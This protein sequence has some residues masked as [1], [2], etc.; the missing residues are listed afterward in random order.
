MNGC[1]LSP[2]ALG[3]AFG[4]L[5][6]I[7][8]LVMGLLAYYYTY[9]HGFVIAM[10]SLYPGYAPSILGSL[11]GGVIGFIDAFITGFIIAWL[12]NVF[13]CCKCMCCDKK[14]NEEVK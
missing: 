2:V 8:I 10:G 13:C 4:V 7:S 12:Y 6:G 1:K 5:W 14:K 9:G 3:L 11:L